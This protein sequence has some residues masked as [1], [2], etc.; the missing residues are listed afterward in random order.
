MLSEH[1]R[2]A[3]SESSGFIEKNA[4][5]FCKHFLSVLYLSPK[6]ICDFHVVR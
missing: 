2:M 4:K 1:L 6:P 3:N 5:K